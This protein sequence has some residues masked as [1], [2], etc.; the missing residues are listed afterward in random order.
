[1]FH[2]IVKYELI[3]GIGG[4]AGNDFVDQHVQSVSSD[5]SDD[6]HFREGFG[7]MDLQ[8]SHG[9][10]VVFGKVG[11]HMR[12]SFS[13]AADCRNHLDFGFEC[14]IYLN[15]LRRDFTGITED[16]NARTQGVS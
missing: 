9:L 11:R 12:R 4:Y 14:S 15:A 13:A 2:C 6:T 16:L 5:L 10:N 7:P 8:L 3:D 1:M